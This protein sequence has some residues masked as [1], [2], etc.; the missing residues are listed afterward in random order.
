V[1]ALTIVGLALTGVIL[2]LGLV[3][4][5]RCDRAD[6]ADVLRALSRFVG[7]PDHQVSAQPV[8]AVR[9]RRR[10]GAGSGPPP[11]QDLRRPA[12]SRARRKRQRKRVKR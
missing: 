8:R 2:I 1:D 6:I 10:I 12:N 4:I 5:L 7:H 11:R 3:A 9:G